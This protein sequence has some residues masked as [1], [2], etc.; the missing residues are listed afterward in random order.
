MKKRVVGMF[1]WE[2]FGLAPLPHNKLLSET[3]ENKGGKVINT[4]QEMQSPKL[5]HGAARALGFIDL[6]LCGEQPAPQEGPAFLSSR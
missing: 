1:F 4:Y 6:G 5:V 2:L 3:I